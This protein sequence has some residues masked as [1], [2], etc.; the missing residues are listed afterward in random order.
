M[1]VFWLVTAQKHVVMQWPMPSLEQAISVVRRAAA[2]ARR[3]NPAIPL[4]RETPERGS[5]GEREEEEDL[6]SELR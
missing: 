1:F 5:K 3:R 2:L 4:Q 6:V